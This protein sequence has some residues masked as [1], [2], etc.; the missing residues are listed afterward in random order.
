MLDSDVLGERRYLVSIAY[1]MLGTVAEAEDAVQETYVRWYRLS[2]TEREAI[3]VPRAWLTTAASRICL[4][5]LGF[6]PPPS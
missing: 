6:G 5:V 2:E 4:N 1:R 3:E